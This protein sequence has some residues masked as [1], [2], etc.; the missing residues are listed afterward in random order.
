VLARFGARVRPLLIEMEAV[1]RGCW[2][3]RVPWRT[4]AVA[5]LVLILSPVDLIPDAIPVVGYVGDL[6]VMPLGILFVRWLLPD[7]VLTEHRTREG[8]QL[9]AA[10]D[11]GLGIGALVG[12]V[13][14]VAVGVGIASLVPD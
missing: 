11:R 8:S 12:G 1:A 14:L 4:K 13:V 10:S 9:R 7:D 5:L 6:L 2:D 3:R